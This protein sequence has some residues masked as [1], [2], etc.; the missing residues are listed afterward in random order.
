MQKRTL[1]II[2]FIPAIFLAVFLLSGCAKK[3]AEQIYE[4]PS[5]DGALLTS[6]KSE[7][8]DISATSILSEDLKNAPVKQ[9]VADNNSAS[10]SVSKNETSQTSGKSAWDIKMDYEAEK[11]KS[12]EEQNK[13]LD[14]RAIEDEATKQKDADLASRR[15]KEDEAT[16]LANAEAQAKVKLENDK[17]AY[18]SAIERL[19]QDY[20]NNL[21]KLQN[22]EAVKSAALAQDLANR[23]LTFSSYANAVKDEYEAKYESLE[24]KYKSDLKA[25]EATKYW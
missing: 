18:E 11:K 23:G 9:Q 16:R 19:E 6:D 1:Q 21:K 12:E 7:T 14:Q 13:I 22:E 17:D 20:N 15:A 25:V 4:K 3:S 5:I 10:D 24:K 2:L 8:Q